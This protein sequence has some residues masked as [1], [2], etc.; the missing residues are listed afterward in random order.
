MAFVNFA[1]A[2]QAVN[3]TNQQLVQFA[4]TS[5]GSETSWTWFSTGGDEI[6]M[7]GRDLDFDG[8]G[9]VTAGRVDRI[10]IDLDNDGAAADMEIRGASFTA[11]LLDDDP[12]SFWN[13]VL[14]GNDI[15]D[16]TGL[17]ASRIGTSAFSS[18]FGDDLTAA[19]GSDRGG[20][21]VITL[22]N[23]LY[24]VAGDVNVVDD[25]PGGPVAVYQGGVDQIL[26]Q[27][28]TL[29]Q[30]L[31][32][33]AFSVFG[34]GIL[35]GG[36][37]LVSFGSTQSLVAGDAML[38]TGTQAGNTRVEGGDDRLEAKA[39]ATG[40][41]SGDV[42]NAL[43]FAD[44]LG[45]DDT[46]TDSDA[47]SRLFGDVSLST[48]SPATSIVGGADEISGNGGDDLL[49]GDVGQRTDKAK[50]IGGDDT[51]SGGNGNDQLFGEVATEG[52]IANVS[53]GNDTLFGD[54]GNDRLF[55]QTGNDKLF[56]GSGNDVLAGGG[57]NDRLE[58]GTQDDNLRGAKGADI[59]LGGD[60]KDILGGDAGRDELTGGAGADFFLF[61]QLGDSG[62]TAATR[63]LITDFSKGQGDRIALSGEEFGDFDFIGKAAFDAAGQIRFRQVDGD[64]QVEFNADA[65][66]A[67]EMQVVLTGQVDLT[68]T[69][70]GF[71]FV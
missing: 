35:R 47:A 67:A 20:N 27:A 53:G 7:T 8:R 59:L 46:I 57:G 49:S 44:V 15:I 10:L 25:A 18:L 19:S 39:G 71:F 6:S 60:G 17:A 36:N 48:G 32:G 61:D 4:N 56:G 65:D 38:A 42:H 13:L 21:D 2:A 70:F 63:D 28:T 58:G 9:R 43:A 54:A 14:G 26:G 31:A 55:G 29:G 24:L 66:N 37:D 62:V 34:A 12:A 68:A 23:G 52:A 5:T 22:G 33:D 1:T 50:I 64:T 51:L 3:L 69:D 11:T 41:V 30:Q 40:T 45:G 16:A